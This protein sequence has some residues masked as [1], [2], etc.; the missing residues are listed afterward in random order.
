VVLRKQLPNSLTVQFVHAMVILITGVTG[1][2][3]RHLANALRKAG[4]RVIGISRTSSGP[5]TIRGDF[6]RDFEAAIWI[7]RLAGVDVVINAV[8]ILRE[9]GEQTFEAVHTRAPRALFEACV[10]AGVKRVIQISALGADT[11]ASGYFRSKHA[12]DEHLASLPL[13][14]TIVQPSLVYGEGGTSAKLFTLFASLP[15]IGVPGRGDYPVQPVHIDDVVAA[16]IALCN[17]P[18]FTFTKIALVGPRA[19]AFRTLLLELRAAMRLGRS[20]MVSIPMSVMRIGARLLEL[21][22]RSLLDRDTLSMLEAGNVADPSD[23]T[24]LLGRSP[25]DVKTFIEPDQVRSVARQAQLEWLLP[26]LRVAIAIVWI[27]TGIVSLG[28]FPRERSLDL[29]YRTGVPASL[30][31]LFLYGAAAL[32]LM[33]GIATLLLRRRQVLWLAQIALIVGYTIIITFKLP[34]FWL[35]PYGPILKNLPMLVAIYA[36]YVLEDRPWNTSS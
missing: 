17:K 36:L 23:T 35:H 19:M 14:W 22:P 4:H 31:P 28:L 11:G 27:W 33:L 25:R 10:P 30:A 1:F 24:Q 7:P 8:G 34:E 29:L 9:V 26:M 32:D 21:S 3:G 13:D 5:D 20:M 18:V 6:A 16:L 2:I 15:V 12:A